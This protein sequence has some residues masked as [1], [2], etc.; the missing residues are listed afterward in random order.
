MDHEI[1]SLCIVLQAFMQRNTCILLKCELFAMVKQ[2]LM[3]SSV[4]ILVLWKQI[5]KN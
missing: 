2:R 4:D 5:K 1:H 3:I